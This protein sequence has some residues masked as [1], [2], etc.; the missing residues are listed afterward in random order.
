MD[1]LK[2]KLSFNLIGIYSINS[3]IYSNTINLLYK[4]DWLDSIESEINTYNRLNT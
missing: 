1:N 3:I 2:D 4:Q